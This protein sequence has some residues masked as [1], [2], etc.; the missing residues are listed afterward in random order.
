MKDSDIN[1]TRRDILRDFWLKC[2][3]NS[4][5]KKYKINIIA[6]VNTTSVC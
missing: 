5:K 4:R 1:E 6:E 3:V 2:P